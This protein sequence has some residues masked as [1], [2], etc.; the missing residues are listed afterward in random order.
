[1][2]AENLRENLPSSS[3]VNQEMG[4]S[5]AA[6][7][8]VSGANPRVV[9]QSGFTFQDGAFYGVGDDWQLM[10]L[11]GS[12]ADYDGLVANGSAVVTHA[13]SDGHAPGLGAVVMNANAAAHWNTIYMSFNWA[14]AAPLI[15]PSQLLQSILPPQCRAPYPPV[16]VEDRELLPARSRICAVSPNPFNPT[17]AIQFDLARPSRVQLQI[18]AVDGTI[19]RTLL[20]EERA[21]AT[22]AR[23]TWDGSDNTGAPVASGVY[24]IRFTASGVSET[25]R[26]VLLK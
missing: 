11:C 6:T 9:S 18:F 1:L 22:G 23:V 7:T 14:D 3:V 8:Q 16:A 19:V 5:L 17:V 21:A 13:Y 25:R 12:L 20:D 24:L 2:L 4:V 26:I 15:R 10:S